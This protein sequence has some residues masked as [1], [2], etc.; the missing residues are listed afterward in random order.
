LNVLDGEYTVEKTFGG[1]QL[2][3]NEYERLFNFHTVS[4]KA[5]YVV[6]GDFVTTADGSGIVHMAPA[7][8][9]DD[10]QGSKQH[11]L[12]TIHPVNKSGEFGPEVTPYSGKFVK[13]ADPLIIQDLKHRNILYKKETVNHSYP[14]CWRC[15]TPLLYY[16]RDS[17]YIA[18]TKYA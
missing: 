7:Y 12:P 16:A 15:K 14:H 5:F 4:E 3:G 11:G 6:A 10:Y 13:D 2:L 8:G 9:E 1:R 18:T 17:W